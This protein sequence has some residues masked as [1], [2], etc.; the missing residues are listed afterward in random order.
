MSRPE[1]CV[2]DYDRV[3]VEYE[4]SLRSRLRGSGPQAPYL[5]KFV[6]DADPVLGVLSLLESAGEAGLTELVV[7]LATTAA[8][9]DQQRLLHATAQVGRTIVHQRD[10]GIALEV[11][12]GAG[13]GASPSARQPIA[14]SAPRPALPRQGGVETCAGELHGSYQ[15]RALALAEDP[16]HEGSID[17]DSAALLH[18]VEVDGARLCVAVDPAS[19]V[20]VRA[21]HS[22][23]LS[24]LTRGTLEGLCAELAGLPILEAAEHGASRLET[25]L[26]DPSE[27]R[28][29]A[30]VVMPEHVGR[31]M[32]TVS[33]LLA[34]LLE[35]HRA[36]TGFADIDSRVWREPAEAWHALD[37][38]GRLEAARAGIAELA[39]SLDLRPDQVFVS[40]VAE[41]ARVRLE[42][43]AEIAPGR[44]GPLL[45]R[46]EEGLR[47]RLDGAV[48]VECEARADLSKIRRL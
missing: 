11:R 3:V 47:Q 32:V 36:R 20:I 6:P 48:V 14:R 41:P 9:I 12:L 27:T 40:S 7:L 18:E 45:L 34:Q 30:G 33:R 4:A 44:R 29:V 16:A 26:R 38:R 25:S 43:S 2:V 15:Q 10:G 35:A 22:G 17:P 39:P 28:C 24:T 1:P 8:G 5:E 46:L 31:A 21:A 37:D 13:V 23:A 19:H 42:L